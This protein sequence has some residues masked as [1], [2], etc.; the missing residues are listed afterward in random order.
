[1]PRLRWATPDS[2]EGLLGKMCMSSGGASPSPDNFLF[3]A[4]VS[5][6]RLRFLVIL[7]GER[8]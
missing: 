5:G 3:F 6:E 7:G 4:G 2:G 1:M 8:G